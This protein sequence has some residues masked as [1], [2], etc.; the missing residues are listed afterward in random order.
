MPA[1]RFNVDPGPDPRAVAY[2]EAKGLKRSWR[3]TSMWG[4]QHAFGFTLAG[5]YR[6]DVLA[7]AHE[8]VTRAVASGETLETFRSAFEERL[9]AL[10]FAGAQTVTDFPDGERRVN[11]SA[12]WRQKVIYDTNVRQAYAA[13]EWQAIEDTAADF[14]AL[15]YNHV[16]QEHPRLQ[17]QAWDKIVLLVTHP[18]WRTHFPP[19]G[20]YCKCWTLQI[21]VAQLASGAVRLTTEA[22][23]AATGYTA[24]PATWP[25]WR[26]NKTGREAH[27]PEGVAPGF[28]HNTGLARREN[29]TDLLARR[30]AGMDPDLARAAAADLVNFPQFADLVASANAIGLAR[31]ELAAT[32]A[33]RLIDQGE[34]RRTAQPHAEAA[35]ARAKPWP[36]E[37]WPVGVGPQLLADAADGSRLVVVNAQAIGHSA[38]Q[39]PTIVGDWGRVQQLLEH[40]EIWKAP[41]G[42]LALFGRFPG[43][44]GERQLW[45]MGLKPVAGAWRLKTLFPTSPR[46]LVRIVRDRQ[47]IREAS[48]PLI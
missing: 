4:E 28:G 39:H 40:G 42:E 34:S 37:A 13:G 22:E 33:A 29:L 21:P 18:F 20:W 12:S 7:A 26:D 43:P 41:N 46:R 23:L 5:V 38:H 16:E 30:V 47:R 14:P 48:G 45:T 3:W 32:E 35:A 27:V 31:A 1:S 8:L 2:L 11:L 24:D 36:T 10:G 17:H 15:Q 6:L 25:V 19:N 9:R 44:D